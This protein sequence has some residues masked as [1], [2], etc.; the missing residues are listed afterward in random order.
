[1][2]PDL[3]PE[4]LAALAHRKGNGGH[5]HHSGCIHNLTPEEQV[6]VRGRTVEWWTKVVGPLPEQITPADWEI[7]EPEFVKDLGRKLTGGEANAD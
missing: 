1:M 4:I 3:K 2:K 6:T 7:E 5:K